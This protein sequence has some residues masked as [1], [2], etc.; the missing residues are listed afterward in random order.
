MLAEHDLNQTEIKLLFIG[1]GGG[2]CLLSVRPPKVILI[3]LN[4][5]FSVLYRGDLQAGK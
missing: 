3:N 4:T 1:L 2:Y 5:P